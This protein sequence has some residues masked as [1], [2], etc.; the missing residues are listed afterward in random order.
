MSSATLPRWA[1]PTEDEMKQAEDRK[2]RGVDVCCGCGNE[3][4]EQD[5]H[6]ATSTGEPIC[7]ECFN[8]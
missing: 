8:P 5:F 3:F 4:P 7:D 6:F 2:R 1:R